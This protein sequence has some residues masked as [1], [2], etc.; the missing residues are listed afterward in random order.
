VFRRAID[1]IG[2]ERILFGTDSSFFPR[3]WN[4]A[5]FTQQS[6]ILYELAIDAS[7]ARRILH[8]NLVNLFS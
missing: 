1:L 6:K 3:G 5:I 8:D 4:A 2:P 7:Q